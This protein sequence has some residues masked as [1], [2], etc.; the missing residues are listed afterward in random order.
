MRVLRGVVVV[1]LVFAFALG[2]PSYASA[3][4]LFMTVDEL[5]EAADSVVA[6]K[7][8]SSRSRDRG[9][10]LGRPDITTEYRLHVSRVLKGARPTEFAL[11]QPHGTVGEYTLVVQDLP[12]FTPGEEAVLFLDAQNRIIGGWQGKLKIERGIVTGLGIGVDELKKKIQGGERLS[13]ST[14]DA[15][16]AGSASAAGALAVP[17]IT[18]VSPPGANCGIGETVTI[19]G[20]NFGSVSGSVQ[21]Q[22]GDS[23]DTAQ[24]VQATVRTWSDTSIVVTVPLKAALFVRVTTAGGASSANYAYQTGFSTNG[25]RWVRFPVTYRINENA[26]STTGEG[27]AIQRAMATWSGAGSRF[28]LAYGGV[29]T[30]TGHP[31]DGE[32]TMSWGPL[33]N[34]VLGTNFSWYSGS[35]YIESDIVFN[36]DL[37]TWGDSTEYPVVDVESVALH[38]L[39]HTVGLDDQYTEVPEVMSAA[40][41]SGQRTLSQVEVNGAIYLHGYD[42]SV[43]PPVPTVWSSTHPT[44]TVWVAED[45]VTWEWSMGRSLV[46]VAGY[47]VVLDGLPD[48]VPAA[49]APLVSTTRQSSQGV[50]DGV[51]YAHVCAESTSGLI[52]PVAHLG[53]RVD[54]TPPVGQVSVAGGQP[55]VASPLVSIESAISDAHSGI[56]GMR[57]SV[58]GGSTWGPWLPVA[59]TRHA[60]MPDGDGPKSVHVQYRDRVGNVRTDVATI[61]LDSSRDPVLARWYGPDRYSTAC[62]IARNAFSS[63]DTVI[64][65]TGAAF[66][67]ALSASGLA[68]V[69]NAPLLL[70]PSTYLPDE[71][72]DTIEY[73]GAERAIIVGGA[74][75]VSA[76]VESELRRE[77]R[78][79]NVERIFGADRYATSAA[80]ANRIAAEAG[81]AGNV[82]IVRGDDFAD[83]LAVS[84]LAYSQA[85]PILLT[86]PDVLPAPTADYITSSG[87]RQCFI[88]GGTGAVSSGVAA[89]LGSL[90]AEPVQRWYGSDRYATAAEAA[91][92]GVVRG[93]AQ[94]R[95]VGVSTGLSFP[96]ALG[97]GV[98]AGNVDGV[99][100]MTRPDRLADSTA[101]IM[102]SQTMMIRDCRVFGGSGAVSEDVY[103]AVGIALQ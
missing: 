93:W 41:W 1:T 68:G 37:Y 74:G 17:V 47:R 61:E 88:A 24:V 72:Q 67:D 22:K 38:E 53:V 36:S 50:A 34:G 54:A 26:E 99:L 55:V 28:R 6:V 10:A 52:G 77:L 80:V 23:Q 14:A 92:Q 49:S 32:N 45:D 97:G 89:T 73:L 51:W 43:P 63:A 59:Q 100:L 4:V 25:I 81:S 44:P 19:T 91:R 42:G 27:A 96:D 9:N 69:F 31:L 78:P 79:K 94:W 33:P 40:E 84:P 39:G 18:S 66:P 95:F 16:S 102:G 101:A 3:S 29:S 60:R 30:K 11:S 57:V 8:M 75:A 90:T 56:D 7:V 87:V 64:I 86:R 62:A 82:F 83:A 15:L 21:F 76:N 35:Q 20:S 103:R 13:V 71:V 12:A 2:A 48:T 58:D 85:M 46:P 5:A 98:A 65:A 70:T